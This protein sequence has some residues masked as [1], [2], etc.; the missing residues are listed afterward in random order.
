MRKLACTFPITPKPPNFAFFRLSLVFNFH[1]PLLP[2]SAIDSAPA[3]TAPAAPPRL[4]SSD[5]IELA[6]EPL[7]VLSAAGAFVP[8][9]ELPGRFGLSR[10]GK[11]KPLGV[12][13]VCV[14]RRRGDGVGAA[15]RG[16]VGG[17]DI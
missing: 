15:L 10:F 2:A 7:L 12:E 9:L 1:A 3:P 13:D 16:D 5:K 8:A 17:V 14:G 6:L 4:L 11:G